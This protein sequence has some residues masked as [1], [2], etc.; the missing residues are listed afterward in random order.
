MATGKARCRRLPLSPKVSSQ[1][2]K[3][4]QMRSYSRCYVLPSFIFLLVAA[5]TSF[6]QVS[7]FAKLQFG[8]RISLEVPRNWRFLNK[9]IRDH[10]NTGA[11]AAARLAGINS[12]QGDNQILMAAQAF[13][14]GTTPAATLRLSARPG[15]AP[16]QAE[17]REVAKL[18]KS[19]MTAA[20]MPVLLE[21]ERGL[22]LMEGI[23]SAKALGVRV[24]SNSTVS[25]IFTEFE[26]VRAEGTR[27]IQTWL[28]P[29]GDNSVKLTT[30]YRKSEMA[31]FKPVILHVWSTLRIQ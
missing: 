11:E 29:T 10:L 30:S 26:V 3:G 13:T 5:S 20:L 8:E 17:V 2:K 31:L 27:L 12:A 6:A 22:R 9:E 28:C 19:E 21:T 14:S 7:S 18:P 25:C 4:A 24:E 16:T 23:Q 1:S 15:P